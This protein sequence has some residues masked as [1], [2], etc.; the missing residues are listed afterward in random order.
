MHLSLRT[1]SAILPPYPTSPL[2]SRAAF[3]TLPLTGSEPDLYTYRGA[4]PPAAKRAESSTT[5]TKHCKD[6]KPPWEDISLCFPCKAEE[7]T[8]G[9]APDQTTARDEVTMQL[10]GHACTG[11]GKF[12]LKAN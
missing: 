4:S 11:G 9:M 10:I 7:S 1:K 5:T 6:I 12:H 2:G 8:S 3:D